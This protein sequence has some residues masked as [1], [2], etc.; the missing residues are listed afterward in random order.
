MM[1]NDEMDIEDLNLGIYRTYRLL[2][3]KQIDNLFMYAKTK[4]TD[5]Q[6][7]DIRIL[8]GV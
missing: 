8:A 6:V 1:S 5:K 7:N 4:V 3:N 2:T